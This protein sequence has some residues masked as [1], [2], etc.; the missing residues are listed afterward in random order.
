MIG[1]VTRIKQIAINLLTNAVK[2]TP[3]GHIILTVGAEPGK[4]TGDYKLNFSVT[5]TGIG[6][7]K[8]DIP[9]LFGNFSQLDTRKNRGIEGTGLG[10]VISKNLVE[11]M[12][13]E[14][15][16]ESKYGE[17]SCFSFYV[18]QK[19]GDPKPSFKLSP[20]ECRRVAVWLSNPEK[21]RVLSKKI[22]Q[23]D[24]PCDIVGSPD[25]FAGYSHVFFDFEQYDSVCGVPC[26]DTKLIALS[27][28]FVD[29][30]C[31][32]PSQVN[33]VHTPLTS[34]VVTWLLDERTNKINSGDRHIE[35]TAIQLHNAHFLV[36][37]DND[38]NLINAENVLTASGAKVSTA[39][40]GAESID[41]VKTNDYD[42]VFMDHMMPEM[43]G[44]DATK[45]IRAL[46]EE[47]YRSL[48]IVALTANVIG[49]VRDMFLESGMNDFLS[50]PLEIHEIER[51]LQ[52]WLP[53]Y[54]WS[55]IENAGADTEEKS[56]V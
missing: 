56:H 31:L 33:V 37:D 32:P 43:D 19:A 46:P 55:S 34:L 8:E 47:K 27:R 9:L 48:I 14:I 5:D 1:D 18:M 20:D 17:G 28:G 2:F 3:K 7:R 24:V 49:N 10:L 35:E 21:S 38:I 26:P 16:V 36:V 6:I 4:N 23:M 45:I 39:A 41:L 15:H 40:S 54:K 52:K 12:D 53:H 44:V 29:E 51:V 11:L 22:I 50:K 13:G 42:M 30:K 25:H